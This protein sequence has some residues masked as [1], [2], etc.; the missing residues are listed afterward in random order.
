MIP[1]IDNPKYGLKP[2]NFEKPK[3]RQ[4]NPQKLS[5]VMHQGLSPIKPP[6][7]R[8]GMDQTL[9][10]MKVLTKGFRDP[11]VKFKVMVD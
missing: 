1:P 5:T 9:I 10:Q 11:M 3:N 7:L 8:F 4:K 2:A 6:E